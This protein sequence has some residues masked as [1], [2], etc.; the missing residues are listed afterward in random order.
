MPS[1]ARF[2]W[3]AFVAFRYLGAKRKQTFVSLI[4]FI[5][6]LGVATGTA[7]LIIALALMTGFEEDIR[8]RI[9]GG[10][11][12]IQVLRLRGGADLGDGTDVSEVLRQV[13]GVP[14]IQAASP[15]AQ[16]YALLAASGSAEKVEL[17]GVEPSG[18][19]RA[20]AAPG[21][22]TAGSFDPIAEWKEGDAVAPI[23][24]GL[25]LARALRAEPGD[26]LQATLVAPRLTPWG[27]IPR[28][29]WFEVAGVFDAGL[30]ESN[31][32]RAFIPLR[33]ACRLFSV[34]GGSW[35]S[36]R[37]EDTNRIA[38]VEGR[39]RA[40]LGAGWVVDDLLARN[41]SL[42]AAMKWEKLTLFIAISLIVC[43]GALNIVSTLILLVMEKVRDIGALVSMGAG[44]R[45]IM[46]LFMLQGLV[47]G[48]AGTIGGVLAGFG[49]ATALD[50]WQIIRLDP[51]VYY[52]SHVPFRAR[53][54]DA[55]AVALMAVAISFLATLYP[56]WKASRLDPAQALRYE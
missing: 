15:V 1:T 38:E 39:L 42:L 9:F 4:T 46:L 20:V 28:T 22:F 52:I 49:A 41:H 13:R 7:A 50:H 36:A 12:H 44:T 30:Y 14:G 43:V 32:T 8:A 48:L 24:L 5:S 34:N 56:A 2:G 21:A 27:V 23:L 45:G 55:L 37:V 19:G 53:P 47:I 6:I 11:A 17:L 25:D 3:E 26:R 29:A 40:A 16:G 31:A 54:E 18:E 10:H 33:L 51:E 35:V